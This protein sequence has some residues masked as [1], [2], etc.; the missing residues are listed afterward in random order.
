MGIV[1]R[2]SVKSAIVTATGA[3]LGAITVYLS[4]LYL[5]KQELGFFRNTLPELALLIAQILLFGLH[6]TLS[7]YIHK[8]PPGTPERNSLLGICL[9]IPII[10]LLLLLPFY[11][12]FQDTFVHIFREEDQTMILTYYNGLPVF[13]FFFICLLLLEQF[14]ISQMKV[15]L[16]LFMREVI[17]RVLLIGLVILYGFQLIDFSILLP[18]SIAVYVIPVLLV[19]FFSLRTGSFKP[20]FHWKHIPPTERKELVTFTWYHFLLSFSIN[21]LNKLDII[22]LSMWAGLSAGAVYGIAVYILSFLYIPYR[23]M[24]SASLPIL[25]QSYQAGD[26]QKVKDIYSRSSLNILVAVSGLALLIASNMHHAAALLGS[27]FE[28]IVPLVFILLV[29]R[30]IE[31]ATGMSEQLLSITSYYRFSFFLSLGIVLVILTGNYLFIPVYGY[32][33]AAV[34]TSLALIIYSILKTGYIQFQLG[35]TPFSRNT[36]VILLITIIA[37]FFAWITPS[38]EHW[39]IDMLIRSTVVMLVYVSLMIWLKPSQ[40]LNEYLA[41]VIRNKRMF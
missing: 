14:L 17:L 35:L 12:L 10:S 22:L 32:F 39:I 34:T 2:Q 4:A 23:T 29:G 9:G 28:D 16:A 33:G 25:T 19:F 7:V 36:L 20:S 41:S 8:Y 26:I 18:A 27:G 13:V 40:D 30:I 11:Y 3:L 24:I 37:G 21:L 38:F 6:S 15:A 31:M 5:P 1:F